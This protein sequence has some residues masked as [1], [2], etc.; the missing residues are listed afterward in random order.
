MQLL[1]IAFVALVV[2]AELFFPEL[3]V[4]F[5][6]A[7]IARGASV[8]KATMD[9]YRQPFPDEGDIGS[10]RRFLPVQAVSDQ[11]DFPECTSQ[12]EFR[13]RVASPIRSHRPRRLFGCRRRH[14]ASARRISH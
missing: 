13:F 2:P 11:S 9:E 6:G 5:G 1:P 14:V 10:S 8:P 12:T 7:R 4:A 3:S